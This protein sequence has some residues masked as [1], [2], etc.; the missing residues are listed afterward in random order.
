MKNFKQNKTI[1]SS[2]TDNIIPYNECIKEFKNRKEQ[3]TTSPSGRYL[4]H[5]ESLLKLDGTQH[6][7]EEPDFGERMMKLHH[8]IISTALINE[9]LFHR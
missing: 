1:G 8:T 5:H 2:T 7:E 3:T 9:S 4:G 6:S